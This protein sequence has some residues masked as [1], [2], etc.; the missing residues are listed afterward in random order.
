MLKYEQGW[1]SNELP[2]LG[3]SD[4]VFLDGRAHTVVKY[5]QVTE[6]VPGGLVGGPRTYKDQFRGFKSHRVHART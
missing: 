4:W 6:G 1:C 5:S 3:C 2:S